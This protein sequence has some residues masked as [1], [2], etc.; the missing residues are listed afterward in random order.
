MGGPIWSAPIH[1]QDWVLSILENVK[2]MQERYPA[3]E[4]ILAVLTTISEVFFTAQCSN[5]LLLLFLIYVSHPLPFYT[6]GRFSWIAIQILQFQILICSNNDWSTI[7][8]KQALR[9]QSSSCVIN[10]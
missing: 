1:D 2:F 10:I 4:K 9:Q 7:N 6:R 8:S 3:Y 5:Y